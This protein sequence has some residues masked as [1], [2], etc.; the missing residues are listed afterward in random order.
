MTVE[1]LKNELKGKTYPTEIR[2]SQDQVV[3][4]V[5]LFLKIQFDGCDSWT[6]DI[7]KCPYYVR[8]VKFYEAT[9]ELE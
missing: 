8:L 1:D 6:K 9:K 2:I 3:I 4:D 5:D 7:M